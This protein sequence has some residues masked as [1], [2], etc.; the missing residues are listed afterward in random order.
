MAVLWIESFVI[1]LMEKWSW[2]IEVINEHYDPIIEGLR[3]RSVA[4]CFQGED[5]LVISR[6]RSGVALQRQ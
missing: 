1:S 4:T 2:T 3:L 6:R 5:Q